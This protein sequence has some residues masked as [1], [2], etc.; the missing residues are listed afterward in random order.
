MA[1]IW[2]SRI[3][4]SRS[5]NLGCSIQVEVIIRVTTWVWSLGSGVKGIGYMV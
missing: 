4:S 5:E 3:Q 2:G 1:G